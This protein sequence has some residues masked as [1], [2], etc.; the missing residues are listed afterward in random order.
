MMNTILLQEKKGRR[1]TVL[2]SVTGDTSKQQLSKKHFIRSLIMSL[3]RNINKRKRAGTSDQN[4]NQLS[5]LK[6]IEI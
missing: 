1:R 3:Y 4:Q 2:T 6:H 5:Q